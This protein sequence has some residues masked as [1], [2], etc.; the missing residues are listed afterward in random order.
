MI[1][2]IQK[3][4]QNTLDTLQNKFTKYQINYRVGNKKQRIEE[5]SNHKNNG[6]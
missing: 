3:M 2:Q 1:D 4:K 6:E 5:Y